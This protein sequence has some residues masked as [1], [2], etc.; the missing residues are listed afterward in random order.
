MY[1]PLG[2]VRTKLPVSSRTAE[3]PAATLFCVVQRVRPLES[4]STRSE[5]L[6]MVSFGE[7]AVVAGLSRLATHTTVRLRSGMP[8]NQIPTYRL[9]LEPAG[10][11]K[12]R[13][14]TPSLEMS[15]SPGASG[16][17]VVSWSS[18]SQKQIKSRKMKNGT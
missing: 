18:D 11:K 4:D 9:P 1:V 17:T 13:A 16:L 14:K 7:E 6:L 12:P 15:I 5:L 8:W 3:A 10:E 2:R